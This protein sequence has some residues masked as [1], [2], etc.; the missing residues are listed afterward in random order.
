MQ[1]CDV[2]GPGPTDRS[3]Y[4]CHP[5]RDLRFAPA[6]EC[7]EESILFDAR[8]GDY[9]VLS[10]LARELMQ[11]LLAVPAATVD[12][13]A[14]GDATPALEA[15]RAAVEETLATLL[16]HRLVRRCGEDE[17]ALPGLQAK[18]D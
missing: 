1:Q 6:W 15:P 11:Q 5:G 7:S 2:S 18:V 8:S 12:A 16:D 4:A 14:A 3:L 17:S 9:W 10:A 13:L